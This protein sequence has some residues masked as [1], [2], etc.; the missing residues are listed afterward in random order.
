M[1][2]A[3]SQVN[4]WQQTNAS[5]TYARASNK[6]LAGN[7]I[8]HEVVW[9]LIWNSM[10]QYNKKQTGKR[11]FLFKNKVKNIVKRAT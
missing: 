2:M 6:G 4:S 11:Q 9:L 7:N 3:L 1:G 10:Y 8:K 5:D